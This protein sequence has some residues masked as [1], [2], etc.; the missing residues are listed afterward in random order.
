MTEEEQLKAQIAQN[1][2]VQ[3][4]FK[5]FYPNYIEGF[6]KDYLREREQWIR[7][8]KM[9][10]EMQ[11]E[12]SIKWINLAA[13]H[14]QYIQQK[15]LFDAQCLWRAGQLQI[16]QVQI[17]ADFVCWEKDVLNCPFIEP[18][19]EADIEL[20]AQFLL[21]QQPDEEIMEATEW[22]NYDMVKENFLD[23]EEGWEIPEWYEFY[24]NHKGTGFYLQLPDIRGKKEEFYTDIAWKEENKGTQETE[25]KEPWDNAKCLFFYKK[26]H[27][28]FFIQHFETKEMQEYYNAQEWRKRN[29]QLDQLLETPLDILYNAD[30]PVPIQAGPDWAEAVKNAA[31]AYTCKKIADTLPEAWEQYMINIQMNIAFPA[32]YPYSKKDSVRK[33]WADRILE[34]RKL[35][36]EPEDFNF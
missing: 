12:H 30:E 13:E 35:N 1:E 9:Y 2:T 21:Q 16:P 15:K 19:T 11:E 26:E 10:A 23:E 7:Y 22:Q 18:I 28:D 33:I 34:G 14:L 17:C 27:R 5:Q 31:A 20:Y 25:P 8:G 24:N 4:Y 3:Q 6:I 32:E 29:S 36:N